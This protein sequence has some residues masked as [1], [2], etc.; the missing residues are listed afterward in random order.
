MPWKLI[1]SSGGFIFIWLGGYAA[2]LGPVLGIMIADYW[3]VRGTH[4]ETAELYRS[5]GLY[6]YRNGWNP[7]ATIAFIV[8]VLPNLP[9]FLAAAF[10]TSFGSISPVLKE[11]YNYGFFVGVLFSIFVYVTLMKSVQRRTAKTVA[12]LAGR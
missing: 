6:S 8:G 3:L 7:A 4:I 11:S 10:P 12:A 1:E 9:G 2:L 5:D